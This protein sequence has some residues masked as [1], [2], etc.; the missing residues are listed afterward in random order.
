MVSVFAKKVKK[1]IHACVPLKTRL[2]NV[3][4][5]CNKATVK[6]LL[7]SETFIFLICVAFIH[8]TGTSTR[9]YEFG[10]SA[11]FYHFSV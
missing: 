11:Y 4:F 5:L 7:I 8:G 6:L 1:K 9:E 10:M 2:E 3:C